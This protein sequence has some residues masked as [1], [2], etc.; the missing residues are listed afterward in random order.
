MTSPTII[1][2]QNILSKI[3]TVDYFKKRS[4]SAKAASVKSTKYSMSST[5]ACMPSSKSRSTLASAKISRSTAYTERSWPSAR[6]STR[7]WWDIMLAGSKASLPI[8]KLSTKQW[9]S[10]NRQWRRTSEWEIKQTSW[11]SHPAI[12]IV[13]LEIQGSQLTSQLYPWPW[14]TSNQTEKSKK[15]RKDAT[16][17]R[18]WT[19]RVMSG[20]MK[21]GT[22]KKKVK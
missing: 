8:W 17:C 5:S 16:C 12:T 18:T 9:R 13:S 22:T 10:W 7:M 1:S 6:C 21:I 19:K 20:W 15:E 11:Q 4:F 2:F 3:D 14:P